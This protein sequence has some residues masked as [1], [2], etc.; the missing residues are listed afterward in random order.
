MT[1][2]EQIQNEAVDGNSDLETVLR[3]CR[4]LASKLKNQ[5]FTAW[6]VRELN[7]YPE[8]A[9]LPKYRI[10]DGLCYGDFFGPAG[11]GA[12][13]IPLKNSEI[14][15]QVRERLTTVRLHEGVASL[16]SMFEAARDSDRG[17]RIPWPADAFPFY[18]TQTVSDHLVLGQAW[19][20]ISENMLAGILSTIRNNILNFI[21]E[22]MEENPNAGEA[23][24]GSQPVPAERTSQIFHNTITIHGNVGSLSGGN[25]GTQ[26]SANIVRPGDLESLRTFLVGVGLPE[27]D[28]S[29]LERAIRSEPELR[30]VESGRATLSWWNRIKEK[31]SSGAITL[32]TGVSTE[33]VKQGIDTFFRQ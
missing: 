3:K 21:L 29:E 12:R 24:I 7:G 8:D 5:E 27:I 28:I 23:P 11:S 18:Q 30:S 22:I 15:P 2:L 20:Q 32:L 6:V 14:L 10:L 16:H 9:A 33:L 1:L 31:I 4:V 17:L 13:N 25:V 26:I 19:T